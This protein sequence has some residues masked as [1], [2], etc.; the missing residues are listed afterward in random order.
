MDNIARRSVH[1]SGSNDY[2]FEIQEQINEI[3]EIL[4]PSIAEDAKS[5]LA[6]NSEITRYGNLIDDVPCDEKY[7]FKS[8]TPIRIA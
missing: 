2:L 1:L 5:M 7:I 3:K 6:H 8:E 4:T